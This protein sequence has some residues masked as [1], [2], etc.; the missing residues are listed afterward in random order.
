MRLKLEPY[1]LCLVQET[2]YRYV[3][4]II[5]KPTPDHT[6]M[7]RRVPDDPA[8]ME[9]KHVSD[10]SLPGGKYK[11]VH[12]ARVSGRGA[13]PTDMLRYDWAA[14]A[15]FRLV[16]SENDVD[17][18]VMNDGETELIIGKAGERKTPQWT[19]ARW[20]SFGWSI[21]PLR[22]LPLEKR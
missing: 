12:Y 18:I 9:E 8:T 3:G 15:T 13:F 19:P 22:T 7:V 1:Q 2:H 6:I 5:S 11:Y 10:L 14:P 21:T 4:Q 17:E 20:A 16:T